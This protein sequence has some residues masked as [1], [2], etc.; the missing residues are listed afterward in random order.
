[1]RVQAAVVVV[2]KKRSLLRSC[3]WFK[4]GDVAEG[5]HS[6]GGGSVMMSWRAVHSMHTRTLLHDSRLTGLGPAQ[7]LLDAGRQARQLEGRLPQC[8]SAAAAGQRIR[9]SRYDVMGN[10]PPPAAAFRPSV[11]MPK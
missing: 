5:K 8:A 2:E 6:A 10:D 7:A 9:S 4:V 1:M 11:P 3:R